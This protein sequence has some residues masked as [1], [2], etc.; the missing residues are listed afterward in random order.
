MRKNIKSEVSFTFTK[1]ETI[2]ALTE[3]LIK[4]NASIIYKG[5]K[6]IYTF[7]HYGDFNCPYMTLTISDDSFKHIL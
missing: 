7:G 4:R 3:Y 6:S 2:K 1:E 5:K